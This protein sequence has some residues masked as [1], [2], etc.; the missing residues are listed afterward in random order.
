MINIIEWIS[1]KVRNH[2]RA[3]CGGVC[4]SITVSVYDNGHR[5]MWREIACVESN[6]SRPLPHFYV[7]KELNGYFSE[8]YGKMRKREK[9]F[10]R[11][12]KRKH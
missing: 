9:E 5:V 1:A 3:K 11:L 10:A 4:H 2:K 8:L 7:A 12:A 6:E